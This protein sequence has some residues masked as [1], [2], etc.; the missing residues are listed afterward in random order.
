[1]ELTHDAREEEGGRIGHVLAGNGW[2][3]TVDGLKEGGVLS[4]VARRRETE[5]T[6]EAGAHVG[7]DVTVQVWH[8]HDAVRVWSRVLNDAQAGSVKEVLV[9]LDVRVFLRHLTAGVEE[10]T[11]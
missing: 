3:G 4:D 6:D 11:V 8:H 1:M 9:V 10:H 7:Q 2:R 5:T